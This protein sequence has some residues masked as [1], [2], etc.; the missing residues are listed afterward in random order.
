MDEKSDYGSAGRDVSP[1]AERHVDFGSAWRPV[2]RDLA[3]S[4][5]IKA[6]EADLDEAERRILADLASERATAAVTREVEGSPA[7][8]ALPSAASD[9][10][11]T[12]LGF[13]PGV[14]SRVTEGVDQAL[15]LPRGRGAAR[16]VGD[17][18]LFGVSLTVDQAKDLLDAW[19]GLMDHDGDSDDGVPPSPEVVAISEFLFTLLEPLAEK[20]S[21]LP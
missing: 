9:P 21:E 19:V 5:D 15:T 12:G 13:R 14:A 2:W 11:V 8:A 7:P 20:L 17:H 1:A 16:V 4:D 6:L 18:A 10:S 3:A